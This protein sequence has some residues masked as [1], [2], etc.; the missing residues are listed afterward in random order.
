MTKLT[1]L[2][3]AKLAIPKIHE[4]LSKLPRPEDVMKVD[5][6]D[7]Y[8]LVEHLGLERTRVKTIK[9]FTG[10]CELQ[11]YEYLLS[12]LIVFLF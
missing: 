8:C 6:E 11:V 4:F 2:F 1:I 10:K 12:S 7:L 5:P 9:R 3:S